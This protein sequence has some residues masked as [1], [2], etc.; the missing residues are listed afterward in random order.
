MKK[1]KSELKLKKNH[2]VLKLILILFVLILI[3][4]LAVFS[5]YIFKSKGNVA[6]AAI[7]IVTDIVG[8]QEP[9]FALLLG[10]SDD[11]NSNLTDTIILVGYNPN[12]QKAFMLSIPRDT[13]V[14]Y[15][16]RYAGGNSKINSKYQEGYEKLRKSVS[17][18][19][20]LNIENYVLIKN[21]ALIE[22]VDVIGGVE[23]NVPID[24]NYDDRTQNL[25][26]HIKKGIQKLDGKKVEQLV[27]FRHNNNG[28]SYPVS[29][30]D[31]DYG[32]MRTQRDLIKEL[33]NQVIS[34]KNITKVKEIASVI[35]N[36]VKT[37]LSLKTIL[38]YIPYAIEFNTNDIK[39]DQLPGESKQ[40][41][42]IWF[43]ENSEEETKELV[44][45]MLNYI[46]FE[47]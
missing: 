6:E 42:N 4:E 43:F 15:N 24:M 20:G 41:N 44:N 5:A 36:N 3:F 37:N 39:M 25:H 28:T 46:E 23:F 10:I 30:G 8:E 17:E 22:T 32:R 35:F 19:T 18:I 12:C 16:K 38:S 27:R 47:Q 29:Y 31:N 13:Y 9:I 2:K 45:Q 21:K 33:A 7:N 34:F 14:G 26:I 1:N 11:L 40:I